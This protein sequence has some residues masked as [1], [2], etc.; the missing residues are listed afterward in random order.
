MSDNRVRKEQEIKEDPKY[1]N[2]WLLLKK[3]RDV[4]WSVEVS[5][6][7]S[8]SEF[9]QVFGAT[10]EDFLESV[11]DAGIEL[12]GSH[13]EDRTQGIERSYKMLQLLDSAIDMMRTKHKAGETYY[14]ILYY[15]YL[16]PQELQNA[17]EI[18]E[19]LRPYI[20]DISYR[21]YYRKRKEA[22]NVLSSLLWGYTDKQ[23]RNI[24][25]HFVPGQNG[26]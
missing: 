5:V 24:L 11:Y 22:I 9:K 8:K 15:T 1:H 6:M 19:A 25:E 20:R 17:D 13:L 2:T 14:W 26:K 18:V 10:V 16:S 23:A 4:T 12:T 7:Q 3:Y 21:T